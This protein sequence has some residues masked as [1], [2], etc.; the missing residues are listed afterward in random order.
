M[1]KNNIFIKKHIIDNSLYYAV[2]NPKENDPI[3][4]KW[5][6]EVGYRF[7]ASGDT[8]LIKTDKFEDLQSYSYYGIF[9]PRDN[10][11]HRQRV[12][13][14]TPAPSIL[15]SGFRINIAL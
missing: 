12:K 4:L 1:P 7:I 3:F 11:I 13:M 8:I 10:T 14:I 15:T 9:S 2:H 6:D 5:G